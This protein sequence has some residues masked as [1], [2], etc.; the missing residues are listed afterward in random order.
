ML[1]ILMLLVLFSCV[2]FFS[3]DCLAQRAKKKQQPLFGASIFTGLNLS[4]LD[5]DE[6]TGFDK[7]GAYIGI[8]GITRFNN[9]LQ[10]NVELIY[11]QAG[12][13]FEHSNRPFSGPIKRD[14]LIKLDYAVAPILFRAYIDDEKDGTGLHI[15]VGAAY[16]HLVNRAVE[17][18]LY[19]PNVDRSYGDKQDDFASSQWDFITGIGYDFT[20]R[21][22]MGLRYTL[23]ATKI[24]ENENYVQRNLLIL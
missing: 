20:R 19:N 24:Y 1:R 10:L 16:A 11:A 21:V 18:I 4:Q 8:R 17:E 22:G 14:R 12:A 15:E 9:R 5:G 23:G 3:P 7:T 2:S 13:L 6:Y